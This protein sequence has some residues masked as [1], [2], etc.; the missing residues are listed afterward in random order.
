[1]KIPS[2]TPLPRHRRFHIEPRY[3]DP[4]KE[5]IAV[6]TSRIEQEIRQVSSSAEQH[7]RSLE[8]AFGR[9]A[10]HRSQRASG[11]QFL[12]MLILFALIFGYIYYGNVVFYALILTAPVY[13]LLRLR[14]TSGGWPFGKG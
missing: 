7:R 14:R 13:F 12:I 5:D 2:L 8:G 9:S 4:I 1:M 11:L 3:Y 6:R 10:Q